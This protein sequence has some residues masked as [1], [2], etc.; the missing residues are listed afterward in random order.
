VTGLTLD[1]LVASTQSSAWT[2][3]DVLNEEIRAGR[4][5]RVENGRV[6]YELTEFGRATLAPLFEGVDGFAAIRGPQ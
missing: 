3:L 5:R 2:L 6:E 4:V 1:D